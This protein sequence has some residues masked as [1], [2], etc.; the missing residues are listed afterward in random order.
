MEILDYTSSRR[1]AG[2]D[3]V[4]AGYSGVMVDFRFRPA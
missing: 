4:D 3:D 1:V 2:L